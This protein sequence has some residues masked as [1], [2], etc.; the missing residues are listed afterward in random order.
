MSNNTGN[1]G[2]VLNYTYQPSLLR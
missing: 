1:D 2:A